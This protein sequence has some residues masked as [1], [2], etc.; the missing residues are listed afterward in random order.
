MPE[1]WPQRLQK[2]FITWNRCYHIAYQTLLSS[3]ILH[4][5]ESKSQPS[6]GPLHAWMVSNKS[7]N[8][9]ESNHSHFP[10]TLFSSM[11][12]FAAVHK[13]VN[14]KTLPVVNCESQVPTIAGNGFLSPHLRARL[15]STEGYFPII[16][17]DIITHCKMLLRAYFKRN[18]MNLTDINSL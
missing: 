6:R 4:W 15:F 10:W 16:S 9:E 11:F 1:K 8:E 7:L 12:S 18:N 13:T 14:S 17:K 3:E 5:N 2:Y